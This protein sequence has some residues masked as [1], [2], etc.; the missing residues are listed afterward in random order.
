[1]YI[2]V[3]GKTE[4]SSTLDDVSVVDAGNGVK[5]WT[6]APGE[7]PERHTA[8]RD[9]LRKRRHGNPGRKPDPAATNAIHLRLIQESVDVFAAR[10]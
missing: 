2:P 8:E 3:F 4:L 7:I 10:Y 1:M 6:P 5:E 9:K